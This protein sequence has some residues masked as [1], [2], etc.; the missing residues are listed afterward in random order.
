MFQTIQPHP[1]L[2]AYVDAYWVSAPEHFAQYRI[3]PDT[4]A[5]IIFNIGEDIVHAGDGAIIIAPHTAFVVGTMTTFRDASLTANTRMLGI[6]F[7]P[8]GLKA[9]MGH[10]L[11]LFTDQHLLLAEVSATWHTTLQNLLAKAKTLAG[12]IKCLEI[13]LLQQLPSGNVTGKQI[14]HTISLIKQSKGNIAVATLAAQVF[15]SNRNYER[16]FL[17]QV[18]VSPKTFARIVR[19][20]AIKQQL[21]AG[22]NG[23]LL[24]LA[25]DNGFYDHAHFTREFS[26]FSG[27]SPT[28]YL[29]Q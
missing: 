15:M 12:K 6:R 26:A 21:K 17:Q 29:Q 2:A 1:L 13:F 14:Q 23:L 28:A 7:Q 25:L 8:G 11:H 19:F 27:Y 10:P 20:I 18:G 22:S 3:L 24:S 4:C 9:F 16:C 5:D